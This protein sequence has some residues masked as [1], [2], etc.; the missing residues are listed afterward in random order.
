MASLLQVS[1]HFRAALLVGW[2]CHTRFIIGGQPSPSKS[3]HA[4]TQPIAGGYKAGGDFHL[5]AETKNITARPRIISTIG[6]LTA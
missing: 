5:L 2:I 1:A 4:S 6:N 3:V